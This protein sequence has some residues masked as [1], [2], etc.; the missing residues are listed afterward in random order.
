MF[1]GTI[2]V[3]FMLFAGMLG[4]VFSGKTVPQELSAKDDMRYIE[5]KKSSHN[6]ILSIPVNG[7]IM[8]SIGVDLGDP[9]GFMD[10]GCS[11]RGLRAS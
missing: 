4:A 6:Q 3:L 11:E 8:G 9:S 1:L 10:L 2:V 7:V 5:G